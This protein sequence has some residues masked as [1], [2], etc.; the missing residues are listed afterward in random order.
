M[1]SQFEHFKE[2]QRREN[3]DR[4][5]LM[6]NLLTHRLLDKKRQ[7]DERISGYQNSSDPRKVRMIPAEKGRFEK[8][9]QRVEDRITELRLKEKTS[10]THELVSAG[11]IRIT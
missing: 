10:S 6:I 11:V 7:A 8:E 2:L 9:K 1:E 5:G 4:I 3:T